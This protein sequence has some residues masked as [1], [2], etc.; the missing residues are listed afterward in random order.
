[1]SCMDVLEELRDTRAAI[2]AS[3]RAAELDAKLGMFPFDQ[4]EALRRANTWKDSTPLQR[5]ALQREWTEQFRREYRAL[6]D[7]ARGAADARR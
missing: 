2:L 6:R 1:M 5:L 3:A 7:Q 4:K